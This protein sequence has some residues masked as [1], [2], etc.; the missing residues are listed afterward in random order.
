MEINPHRSI[1]PIPK[2]ER[3]R[4][5]SRSRES[6]LETEAAGFAGADL[7]SAIEAGLEAL[8][9]VRLERLELGKKLAGD[10]DYPSEHDLE[11]LSDLTLKNLPGKDDP[12][13]ED[14]L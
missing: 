3:K 11:E 10:P 5:V 14:E 13:P 7:F 1:P 9:E 12:E 6:S 4:R 8:P 2:S